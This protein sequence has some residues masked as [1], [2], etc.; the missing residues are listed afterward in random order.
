MISNYLLIYLECFGNVSEIQFELT[1]EYSIMLILRIIGAIAQLGERYA[2]SV[3]GRSI[4]SFVYITFIIAFFTIAQLVSTF[5]ITKKGL[6][7]VNRTRTA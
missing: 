7:N 2:G 4:I 3:E 6:I 1:T 5:V